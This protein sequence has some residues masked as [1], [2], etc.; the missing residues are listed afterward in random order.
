MKKIFIGISLFFSLTL[1]TACR[2]DTSKST[3]NKTSSTQPSIS[4]ERTKEFSFYADSLVN[5]RLYYD[6]HQDSGGMGVN[7]E[8]NHVISVD[9]G[10]VTNYFVPS[11]IMKLSDLKGLT[12]SQIIDK[13]KAADKEGFKQTIEMIKSST[14]VNTDVLNNIEYQSPSPSPLNVEAITDNSG[15]NIASETLKISQ[16]S[17]YITEQERL[18]LSENNADPGNYLEGLV[19]K[20]TTLSYTFTSALQN[21][22]VTVFNTKYTGFYDGETQKF[23]LTKYIDNQQPKMDVITQKGLKISIE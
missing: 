8:I 14:R 15:N 3:E 2:S 6:V 5:H 23:L 11:R 13:V 16:I 18:T 7:T 20:Q 9:N 1:L 12:D 17:G 19:K 21:Q 10:K 4:T 22:T